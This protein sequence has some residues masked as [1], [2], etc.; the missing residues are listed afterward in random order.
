MPG[1][2]TSVEFKPAFRFEAPAS[3]VPVDEQDDGYVISSGD[4]GVMG[5]QANPIIATN[6]N[7]CVGLAAPNGATTVAGIIAALGSD[8][9]FAATSPEPMTIGQYEGQFIDIGLDPTWTGT[10]KWSGGKPAAVMLTTQVYPGPFFG[11]V[12]PERIRLIVLDIGDDVVSVS[13]NSRLV[14][15]AESVVRSLKFEAAVPSPSG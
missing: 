13:V 1:T 4:N 3:W 10:C 14:P 15:E 6:E 7:D 5:L 9:R 12:D 11:L 8:P 2:R